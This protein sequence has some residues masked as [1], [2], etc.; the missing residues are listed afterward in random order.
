MEEKRRERNVRSDEEE[1]FEEDSFLL[2]IVEL[3]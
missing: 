1:C 2:F 3:L